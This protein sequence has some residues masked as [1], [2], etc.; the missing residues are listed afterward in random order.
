MIEDYFEFNV[1]ILIA[2]S[3][4]RSQEKK[5]SFECFLVNFLE[6]KKTTMSV[7]FS[8]KCIYGDAWGFQLNS[9]SWRKIATHSTFLI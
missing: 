8:R 6:G 2:F 7:N 1:T 9:F 5:A 4:L 3:K